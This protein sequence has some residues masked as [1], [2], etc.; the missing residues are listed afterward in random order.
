MILHL[1][2]KGADMDIKDFER[3]SLFDHAKNNQI[4][5]DTIKS[6]KIENSKEFENRLYALQKFDNFLRKLQSVDFIG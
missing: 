5:L 6:D 2:E 1:L 4:D 3:L